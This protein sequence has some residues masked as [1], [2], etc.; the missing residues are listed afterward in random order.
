MTEAPQTV[1]TS[2]SSA[3]NSAPTMSSIWSRRLGITQAS[4]I[5]FGWRFNLGARLIL[6]EIWDSEMFVCMIENERITLSVG[7][8]PF[9]ADTLRASNLTEGDISS[10]R[11]FVVGGAPIPQTA[12]RGGVPPTGVPA[13]P[14]LGHDGEQC[15][16]VRTSKRPG[17]AN[18]EHTTPTAGPFQ[19]WR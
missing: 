18:R 19:A 7:A 16:E 13:N 4:N 15:G 5:V 9:L 8:T 17:G 1:S 12:A 3:S 6:H 2:T 11:I 10:L 14:G